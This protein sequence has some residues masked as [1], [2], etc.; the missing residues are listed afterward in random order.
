MPS[1]SAWCG[2]GLCEAGNGADCR[3][4][5]ADRR[6]VTGG[7]PR[8]RDCC[9]AGEGCGLHGSAP[10]AVTAPLPVP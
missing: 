4:C 5:A 3:T 6:G 10:I 1:T 7:K 9:G 8:N 2:N